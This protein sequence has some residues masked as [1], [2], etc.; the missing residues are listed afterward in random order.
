MVPKEFTT[1]I[2]VGREG[3][4][5]WKIP[6]ERENM[7]TDKSAMKE[8]ATVKGNQIQLEDLKVRVQEVSVGPSWQIPLSSE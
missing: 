7:V 4:S 3:T 1:V 2:L 8:G 5:L 6:V